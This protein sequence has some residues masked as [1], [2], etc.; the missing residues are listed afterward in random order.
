V[1]LVQLRRPSSLNVPCGLSAALGEQF[2]ETSEAAET[3]DEIHRQMAQALGDPAIVPLDPAVRAAV[4]WARAKIA[5][6]ATMHAEE[7]PVELKDPETGEVIT[8]GTAD[9][10]FSGLMEAPDGRRWIEVVDWKTGRPERVTPPVDN[11]QL[12]AYAL[13]LAL[14]ADACEYSVTIGHIV[15]GRFW[16]SETVTVRGEEMWM[17]LDRIKAECARPANEAHVGGHC[18]RCFHVSHCA[19]YMLPAYEGPSALEPFTRPDGLTRDNALRALLVVTAL[20][21]AAEI[22]RDRLKAFAREHGPIVDGDKQ[23]GPVM[24]RGKRSGASV[25]TLEKEGLQRL[26]KEGRP[27]ERFEWRKRAS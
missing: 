3:G 15:D 4:E 12:H 22:G 24:V 7:L 5:D 27:S 6:G 16:A 9:F 10:A 23:W 13:A 21:A 20:E 26:I 8:K 14:E 19:A 1:T 11:L 18:D 17:Y 2:P 25:E